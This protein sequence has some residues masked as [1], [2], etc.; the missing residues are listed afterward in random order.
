M[1]CDLLKNNGRPGNYKIRHSLN[2]F[3]NYLVRFAVYIIAINGKAR[4]T[5]F[6]IDNPDISIIY[7][8]GII[9]SKIFF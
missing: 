9:R 7:L 5:E 8:V 4:S 6:L 2:F 1:Y 3:C